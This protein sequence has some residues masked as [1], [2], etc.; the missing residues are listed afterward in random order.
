[1][2]YTEYTLLEEHVKAK[3]LWSKG[4]NIGERSQGEYTI[5]LYQLH[6]FYVE[7]VYD[8]KRHEIVR[9]VPFADTQCLE[10]YLTGIDITCLV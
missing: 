7:V 2:T 4:V 1:M 9:L 3:D 6:S 8:E 5:F 10:P